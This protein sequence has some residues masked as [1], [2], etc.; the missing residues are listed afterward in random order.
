MKLGRQG[1]GVDSMYS[2][3]NALFMSSAVSL[4]LLDIPK[5]QKSLL[6]AHPSLHRTQQPP[7][8]P[9]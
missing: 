4:A 9:P 1:L 6:E 7:P 3:L 5:K 8:P 2:G